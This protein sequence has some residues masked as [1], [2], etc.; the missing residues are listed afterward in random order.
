MG[1][2]VNL[3]LEGKAAVVVGGGMLAERKVESLLAAKA[4]VTVVAPQVCDRIA[5]LARENRVGLH[6]RPYRTEDLEGAF[7][8]IAATGDEAV[9][10]RVAQDAQTRN[11]LVNVVDR[12]ALCTFTM[13]AIVCR[14]DLTVAVATEGRCPALAS[15]LREELEQRYGP[16]YASLV[17]LF[18]ELRARMIKL[19][20][21]GERIRGT[22]LQLYR[23]GVRERIAAGNR[24][25]LRS[26]LRSHLGSEFPLP[27]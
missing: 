20:W 14:G 6:A 18:G 9:N 13:P 7:V 23:G 16:D 1:Y 19:G 17:D 2:M 5:E 15:I 22:L 10:A 3:V 26:F 12:P 11:A 24:G 8:V 25:V 4:N 27:E 21:N